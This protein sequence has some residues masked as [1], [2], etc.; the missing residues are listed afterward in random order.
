[1][2]NTGIW[3]GIDI[4]GTKT[5]VVLSL[6]PPEVLSR[7]EFPSLPAQG[8][9]RAIREIKSRLQ[10]GLTALG[11]HRSSLRSIGISCGGPLDP[12]AGI[13]QAPPNLPTWI[14]V[15]IVQILETEFQ[16][17]VILE[18]DANA[19]A[20]AEYRYGAGKGT[21][22]M[23][24]LTLGTGLGAGIIIGG[25]LYRGAS[26]M[27][28]EIGH[29]RLTR[30][31]PIGHNKAGSAEG[32][33]SGAGLAQVAQRILRGARQRGQNSLL[34]A[35]PDHQVTAKDVGQ[36]A[37]QGDVVARNIV[38]ICG[39]RLGEAL[40]VL[41]DVLN[42]ERIV[43]GG[44]AV[45]LGDLLL[46]PARASL[47]REAVQPALAACSVVQ[48]KLGESIGDVAALCVAMQLGNS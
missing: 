16:C 27:A 1:M 33:A 44:L 14:D 32:W 7:T 17:R 39:H 4:G 28:G 21:S 13:I 38:R 23:V 26:N 42:P 20:L 46:E 29:V 43:I 41:V 19:G 25:R 31:G 47:Q 8:P 34:D 37:Q 6:D 24:F 9:D 35:L 11:T 45:R 36:A 12:V 30:S 15:P 22:E 48:A 2:S 40:A 18:N 3:A 5:A 10:E